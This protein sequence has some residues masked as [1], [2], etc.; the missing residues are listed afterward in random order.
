MADKNK[1]VISSLYVVYKNGQINSTSPCF[2]SLHVQ[3]TGS[4]V[5][6][7]LIKSWRNRLGSLLALIS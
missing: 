6:K 4:N 7:E 3:L 5:Y 1:C 2:T